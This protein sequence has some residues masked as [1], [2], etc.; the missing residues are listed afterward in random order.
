MAEHAVSKAGSAKEVWD[1]FDSTYKA[2]SNTRLFMLLQNLNT[3]KKHPA[4]PLAKY[5]ARARAIKS[6]YS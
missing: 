5:F 3:I 1:H 4:E 2:N 6:D